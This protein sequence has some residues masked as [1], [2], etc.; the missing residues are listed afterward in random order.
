MTA[1]TADHHFEHLAVLHHGAD[2]L[3]RCITHQVAGAVGRGDAVLIALDEDDREPLI[4]RLGTAAEG[5][6]FLTPD[7]CYTNPGGAMATLHRTTTEAVDRGVE[8]WSFGCI[9]VEGDTIDPRWVR[10]EQAVDH[11]LGHLPLHAVCCYDL[12]PM[13]PDAVDAVR[14]THRVVDEPGLGQL[15]SGRY[16]ALAAEDRAGAVSVPTWP[17]AVHVDGADTQSMRRALAAAFGPVLTADRLGDL[18]L[19]ATELAANGMRHGRPPVELEAWST[20]DEIVVRVSDDGTGI[21]DPFPDLRPLAGGDHGG[22]GLW[23]IGQ[24]ADRVVVDH[25]GDRAHVAIALAT[26]HR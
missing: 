24:L 3:A 8:L 11:V 12:R 13:A 9:P 2:D 23:L 15:P 20:G 19:L 16:G 17:P 5:A 4:A 7:G 14:R 10:Y 18:L 22:F 6:V 25:H 26:G 21:A 1:V